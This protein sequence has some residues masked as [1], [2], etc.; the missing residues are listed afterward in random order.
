[1]MNGITGFVF[2]NAIFSNFIVSTKKVVIWRLLNRSQTWASIKK[3]NVYKKKYK[4]NTK[5]CLQNTS[6]C[7]SMAN[8]NLSYHFGPNS[9]NY[10]R[11]NL[12]ID[13][14]QVINRIRRAI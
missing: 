11:K 6:V 2:K 7:K 4:G 12:G 3:I 14:E 9:Q 13:R 10:L 1:M 8:W 5:R